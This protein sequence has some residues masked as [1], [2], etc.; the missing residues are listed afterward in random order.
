MRD[1]RFLIS[2]LVG[3]PLT[4]LGGRTNTI[5]GIE[6]ERAIVATGRSPEGQPVPIAWVQDALDLLEARGEVRIE[7][8]TV[9]YRSAFHRSRSSGS[10]GSRAG[11]RSADAATL[12]SGQP[13]RSGATLTL[14]ITGSSTDDRR[15]ARR[16]TAPAAPPTRSQAP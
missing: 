8:P 3:R 2:T 6:G 15:A 1:A 14:P 16:R 5:R 9:S 4:T 10:G 12:G 13:K 7:P 11:L